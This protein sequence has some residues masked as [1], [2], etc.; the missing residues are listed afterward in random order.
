M[1]VY[2]CV[3]V[4]VCWVG[5][6]SSDEKESVRTPVMMKLL[7]PQARIT[8]RDIHT[9]TNAPTWNTMSTFDLESL[10]NTS[11]SNI[12]DFIAA[13]KLRHPKPK[14][15][16]PWLDDTTCSLRQACWRAKRKWN[17]DRLTVSFDIFWNSLAAFQTAAKKVRA[18]H[19]QD[20]INK[21]SHR[22]KILF[23]T[24]NSIINPNSPQRL[25]RPEP[26]VKLFKSSFTAKI[27]NIKLSF[28]HSVSSTLPCPP[29][30]KAIFDI[31]FTSDPWWSKRYY[32]AH[33]SQL[34]QCLG[35]LSVWL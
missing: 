3:C 1:C 23:S 5:S 6:F 22:P 14:K 21:H 35:A 7:I 4:H 10:F 28:T 9:G 34:C 12:L 11:C 13:L 26:F 33:D 25:K 2:A 8:P 17:K 24:M 31:F 29:A 16:Q 15:S 27:E 32:E 18:K 30:V 20:I 19:S